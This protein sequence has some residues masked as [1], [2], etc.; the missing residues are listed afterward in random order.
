MRLRNMVVLAVMA[1]LGV[2]P[3]LGAQETTGRIEGRIVDTQNLAVP[4]VTVTATGPQGSK[5]AVS[6]SDGRF[7]IPFLTPG[8]YD[9]K[10]QLQ[11][12]KT[13]EQKTV[14]SVS[15]RRLMSRSAWRLAA[16]PKP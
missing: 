16:S 4:G 5:S 1:L 13:F 11:G 3:T 10:A 14:T 9:V 2:S 6:D 8:V 15:G 12:F 7:A